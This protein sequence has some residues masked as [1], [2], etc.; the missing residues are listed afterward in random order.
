MK[1][2]IATLLAL[3]LVF[4]L[5]GCKNRNEERFEAFAAELRESG[6]L[7]VTAELRVEYG[8]ST[9]SFTLRCTDEDGGYCVEVL[10]P[11]LIRGVRAHLR[12][13]GTTLSF[14]GA[15]IDAGDDGG[16]GLTPMGALPLLARALREGWVDSVW[17]EDGGLAVKLIPS[18]AVSVTVYFDAD[19]RPLRAELAHDGAV[20]V[21]CEI[22]EFS[23]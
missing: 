10:E 20:V 16:T 8:E 4:G 23:M 11:E 13:G 22:K 3:A 9:S 14:D 6:S 15:E 19:M 7:D 5:C 1:R 2:T 12:G 18:D 17:K 21:F